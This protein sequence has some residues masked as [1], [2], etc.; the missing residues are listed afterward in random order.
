MT[1]KNERQ[2]FI[3]WIN[4]AV[5][6]G[7]RCAVACWE[8]SLSLRTWRRWQKHHED[9]R[10]TAVRPVPVNRLSAEEERQIREVCH[11]PVYAS[12]PPSQIVPRLA[13]SGIYL[14]SESTFYRVLRRH[15][16]VHH[17]AAVGSARTLV[18]SVPD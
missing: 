17:R 15:G 4:E 5:A 14:A 1:P 9:G 18:L 6:A 3:L 10:T 11:Q 12:L 8:V 13:D 7:A 2:Q 16:E